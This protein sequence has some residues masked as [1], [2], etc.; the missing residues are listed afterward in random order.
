MLISP[1]QLGPV[2]SESEANWVVLLSSGVSISTDGQR[3]V[4]V[5]LLME[6]G[7]LFSRNKKQLV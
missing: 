4:L 3:N 1:Q 6:V 2:V 7:Y 5:T